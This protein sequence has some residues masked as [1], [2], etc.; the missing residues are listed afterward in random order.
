MYQT[1]GRQG[2]AQNI[3]LGQHLKNKE[4]QNYPTMVKVHL[5]AQ[6][7]QI[8]VYYN[9]QD[10]LFLAQKQTKP[11]FISFYFTFV[12]NPQSAEAAVEVLSQLDKGIASSA[13]LR[14]QSETETQPIRGCSLTN[15]PS[16]IGNRA[17]QYSLTESK[18]QCIF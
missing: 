9:S 18:T 4:F 15:N 17:P 6:H 7:S 3:V 16:H 11:H 10:A 13:A 12:N 5:P 1:G 8:L 14:D 2:Q